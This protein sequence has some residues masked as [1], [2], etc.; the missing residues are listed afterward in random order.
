MTDF[1]SHITKLSVPVVIESTL[2]MAPRKQRNKE[3]VFPK[4]EAAG[5]IISNSESSAPHVTLAALKEIEK[6]IG[7]NGQ[8]AAGNNQESKSFFAEL[9]KYKNESNEKATAKYIQSIAQKGGVDQINSFLEKHGFPSLKLPETTNKDAVSSAS[10]FD[11]RVQWKVPGIKTMQRLTEEK[12]SVQAVHIKKPAAFYDVK[13]HSFPVVELETSSN[14]RFFI[15]RFNKELDSKDPLAA[16]KAAQAIAS[17]LEKIK[18]K[19][20]R[21]SGYPDGVIFPMASYEANGQIDSLIGASTKDQNGKDYPIG[22]A[23]YVHRFRL[24]EKGA[25]AEAG[26]AIM[27]LA[28]AP[29]T[30]NIDGPYLAW[31]E[32]PSNNKGHVIPFAVLITKDHMKDPGEF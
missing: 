9:S 28:E 1:F 19:E 10:V 15:T 31:F 24:N 29:R 27:A 23:L 13:G 11:I 5:K 20:L 25:R 22:N 2:A 12:A 17:Q 30:L 26:N 6:I 21:K 8:W 4:P 7:S 18:D 32:V 3:A 14:E 16:N